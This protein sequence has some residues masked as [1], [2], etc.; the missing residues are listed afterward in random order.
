LKLETAAMQHDRQLVNLALIG[1]MGTGKTSVG[2][3]AAELLGFDYLDTD[4]LIQTCTGRTIAEIFKTDGETVFRALEKKIVAELS[5]RHRL[6]ISTGG[7]LPADSENLASLKT[8]ALVVCLWA[9]PEKIW[10]RV[11]SQSHRPLLH[12]PDPQKKI[13]EL[14]AAREPFYKQADVLM[15]TEIRTVREMA[16]QVAHQFRLAAA[17]PK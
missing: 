3:L 2:R 1:F 13:R 4:E 9:S 8:H 15:N 17:D 7:G 6:V 14:L 16:Q 12:D 11:R 10:E 5:K